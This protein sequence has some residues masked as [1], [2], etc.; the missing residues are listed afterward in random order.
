[1]PTHPCVPHSTPCPPV[2]CSVLVA[3]VQPA[4]RAPLNEHWKWELFGFA[5]FPLLL[6]MPPFPSCLVIAASTGAATR[7]PHCANISKGTSPILGLTGLPHNG[8]LTFLGFLQEGFC[9]PQQCHKCQGSTAQSSIMKQAERCA[10]FKQRCGSKCP[11]SHGR[12][13][14]RRSDF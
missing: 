10:Y 7:A 4:A 8:A 9:S 3:G 11:W 14:Q 6:I 1:M 5:L 13:W 2:Q 12:G